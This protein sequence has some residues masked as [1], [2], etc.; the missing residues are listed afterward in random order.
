[1]LIRDEI[2]VYS[3]DRI[4]NIIPLWGQNAVFDYVKAGGQYSDHWV[5][6]AEELK[7][8]RKVNV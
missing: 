4:R 2:A 6:N 5:L 3:E 7:L 8:H 1:M